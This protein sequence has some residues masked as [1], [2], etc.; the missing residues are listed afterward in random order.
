MGRIWAGRMPVTCERPSGAFYRLDPDG[1]LTQ[2][3]GPYTIANGPAIDPA[4]AFLLHTDTARRPIF[5]FDIHDDGSLG[6]AMP[7]ILFE[8]LGRASCRARVRHS[9]SISVSALSFKKTSTPSNTHP[10]TFHS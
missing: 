5:R 4:G 2:V 8:A 1:P 10:T 9:A 6:A 3:D 7:F